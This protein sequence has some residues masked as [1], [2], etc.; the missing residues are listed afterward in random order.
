[1]KAILDTGS[2]ENWISKEIVECLNLP[3]NRGVVFKYKEADGSRLESGAT[4]SF[5]WGIQGQSKTNMAEFRVVTNGTAPFDVLLGSNLITSNQINFND[6]ERPHGVIV[7]PE[8]T[9]RIPS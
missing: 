5:R 9:V 8:E 4:V 6:E 3:V 1:M 2:D 7:G